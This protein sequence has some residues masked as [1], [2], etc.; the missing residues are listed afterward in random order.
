MP[1]DLSTVVDMA[2]RYKESKPLSTKESAKVAS[3]FQAFYTRG[4]LQW[5]KLLL[6]DPGRGYM[7]V[8]SSMASR[9]GEASQICTETR[10]SLNG[11]TAHSRVAVRVPLCPG[12]A[13]SVWPEVH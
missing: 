5:E 12:D 10:Q 13:A 9:S 6:V 11:L 4:P 8:V 7:G 3:A 2:S 1:H